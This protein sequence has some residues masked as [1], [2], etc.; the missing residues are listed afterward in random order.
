[1]MSSTSRCNRGGAIAH[2]T[3]GTETRFLCETAFAMSFPASISRRAVVRHRAGSRAS[4]ATECLTGD[5]VATGPTAGWFGDRALLAPLAYSS[6]DALLRARVERAD[7]KADGTTDD[8]RDHAG[9]RREKRRVHQHE[10]EDA[11]DN[12]RQTVQA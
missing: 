3:E 12:D 5:R 7:G 6:L 8:E 9:D 11:D 10:P 2:G 1:M 4:G